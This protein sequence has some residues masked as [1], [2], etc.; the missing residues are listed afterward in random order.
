MK[1]NKFKKI[2]KVKI[3]II[4]EFGKWKLFIFVCAWSQLRIENETKH[5]TFCL[6]L[7]LGNFFLYKNNIKQGI[8]RNIIVKHKMNYYLLRSSQI[9]PA[10]K[11][12]KNL[13]SQITMQYFCFWVLFLCCLI[14][15]IIVLKLD[16][17]P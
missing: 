11:V 14:I 7:M 16:V 4:I 1:V 5:K 6:I 12:I 3:K 2:H 8:N 17:M 15:F 9:S 10:N 13:V